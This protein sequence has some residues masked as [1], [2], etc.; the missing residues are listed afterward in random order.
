LMAPRVKM[1][2]QGLT[3]YPFLRKP[4]QGTVVAKIVVSMIS[5]ISTK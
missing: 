4:H 5:I 2:A 1:V 3:G